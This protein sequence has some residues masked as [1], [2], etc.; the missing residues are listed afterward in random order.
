LKWVLVGVG[1]FVLVTLSLAIAPLLTQTMTA[2]LAA[3][4]AA[5][6]AESRE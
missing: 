5:K 1:T 2:E 6:A 3:H 4:A